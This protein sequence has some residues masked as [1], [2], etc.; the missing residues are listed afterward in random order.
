MNTTVTSSP[1]L[2]TG[3]HALWR[4]NKVVWVGPLGA[5]TEDVEY[6]KVTLSAFDF[7]LLKAAAGDQASLSIGTLSDADIEEFRRAT[8][9]LWPR[10]LQ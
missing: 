9:G 5:P 8:E 6:D 10:Q 7:G 3:M 2:P 4:G 1:F